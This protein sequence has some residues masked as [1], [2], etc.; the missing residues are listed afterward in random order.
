MVRVRTAGVHATIV[1]AP[2]RKLFW[3]AS[4]DIPRGA[5]VFRERPMFIATLRDE[6]SDLYWSLTRTLA[7]ENIPVQLYETAEHEW[8]ALDEREAHM[9]AKAENRDASAIRRIFAITRAH[10]YRFEDDTLALYLLLA[11]V[12]QADGAANARICEHPEH[13]LALVAT[14]HIRAGEEI[15]I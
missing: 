11:H 4:H 8:D 2:E 12:A 6:G 10:A 13:A 9:V 14:R 3:V 7:R 15:S 5:E 1:T